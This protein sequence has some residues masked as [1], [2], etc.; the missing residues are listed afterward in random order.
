[1]RSL[2]DPIGFLPGAFVCLSVPIGLLFATLMPPLQVPDEMAHF[3]RAYSVSNGSCVAPSMEK[4][5]VAL[6]ELN[7]KFPPLLET[8]QPYRLSDYR[9]FTN[10][11]WASQGVVAIRN[12]A[13]N[14]YH[15]VPYLASAAGVG[16]A[17]LSSQSPIL[18]LYWAR[19]GNLLFFVGVVYVALRIAPACRPVLFCLAL[20]P[21]TLH[22]AASASADGPTIASTFL[23]FAYVL[24]L[25]ARPAIT[26]ISVRQFALLCGILLFATLC[27]F[28]VW[29]ALLVLLIPSRKFGGVRRHLL[30]VAFCVVVVVSGWVVWRVQDRIHM[31]Y[32]PTAKARQG[33]DV[34]RNGNFLLH[35]AGEYVAVLERTLQLEK[36][37]YANE[38]VGKLGWLSV[39][40]P[41]WLVCAYLAVLTILALGS[42]SGLQ[43]SMRCRWVCL[44]VVLGSVVSICVLLWTMEMRAA[45]YAKLG[46][47]V[48][49]GVQGRYLIPLAPMFYL[50]FANRRFRIKNTVTF[51]V[52]VAL[53]LVSSYTAIA[54]VHRSYYWTPRRTLAQAGVFR[55]GVWVLDGNDART[56]STYDSTAVFGQ[57]D[58]I[59]VAGDWDGRGIIRIGVFRPSSGMWYLDLNN[60][61]KWDGAPGDAE[62]KYGAPGDVPVVGDWNGAGISR[63]GIFRRGVWFLDTNG[64][65]TF[66][67]GDKVFV[68]GRAG[69][70]PVVS[71]WSGV[72]KAD[73]I[74]VFRDGAW[75]VDSDGDGVYQA[76]DSQYLYGVAGDQPLVGNWDGAGRKR[77]GVFRNGTWFLNVSGSN[78]WGPE[79]D[80]L[81]AFGKGGDRAVVGH[82]T[83]P[84][85]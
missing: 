33:V 24:R 73:Q 45:A 26:S 17:R 71:N 7:S 2:R 4:V 82:W 42:E 15:C 74:G 37:E 57:A 68:Y 75:F 20:M 67:Q 16:A 64:N 25:A 38:F 19:I 40:L 80:V 78:S 69:D 9:Y 47:V 85:N 70:V 27:K 22:Q 6:N 10:R 39:T 46:D 60:N 62:Y 3:V 43:V 21:M 72:G 29:M 11:I 18:M 34:A 83:I 58:D 13:A 31:Q 55:R 36:M 49:P 54:A 51:A 81:A 50:L 65:H 12:P 44:A 79:S 14:L 52:C 30:A 84:P 28:N 56:P 8:R 61:G 23:L 41:L 32:L 1:M 66:D 77:I 5:P 53:V 76:T 35:H 59:P 48:Q 63:I